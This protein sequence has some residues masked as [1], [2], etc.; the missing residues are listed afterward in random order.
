MATADEQEP[1]YRHAGFS[2]RSLSPRSFDRLRAERTDYFYTPKRGPSAST[3]NITITRPTKAF[4]TVTKFVELLSQA[5]HATLS[6]NLD[7]DS[8][9]LPNKF[10]DRRPSSHYSSF[11][12]MDGGDLSS[13]TSTSDSSVFSSRSNSSISTVAEE[14]T[15]V[16]V[17][18]APS[19]EFSKHCLTCLR[20]TSIV[21]VFICFE[22]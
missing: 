13:S 17:I 19:K 6:D 20:Q 9:P 21:I 5:T 14:E 15:E 7:M 4:E 12:S 18:D 3:S 22:R 8:P 1:Q 10:S 16:I 11:M 2:H